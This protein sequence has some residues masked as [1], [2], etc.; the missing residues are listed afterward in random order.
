MILLLEKIMA[1]SWS[2]MP[3]PRLEVSSLLEGVEGS[4]SNM[5]P[6]S[7]PFT[8]PWRILQPCNMDAA[9]KMS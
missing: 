7:R 3:G 6:F 1:S 8:A 5:P 9:C 2:D 4:P